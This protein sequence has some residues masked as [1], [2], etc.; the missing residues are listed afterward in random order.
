MLMLLVGLMHLRRFDEMDDAVNSAK[1]TYEASVWYD[2]LIRFMRCEI[3]ESEL[4]TYALTEYQ[5]SELCYYSGERDRAEGRLAQA[6]AKFQA[7]LKMGNYREGEFQNV[8][9]IL[10]SGILDH[11]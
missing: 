9:A 8:Q 2:Q 10:R 4:S 1:G 7:R 11:V 3:D 6:K 5:R